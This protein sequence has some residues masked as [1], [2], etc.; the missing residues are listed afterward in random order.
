MKFQKSTLIRPAKAIVS[1][2]A[3][4]FLCSATDAGFT[5]PS[6]PVTLNNPEEINQI[7]VQNSNESNF[8]AN[9]I[10]L[11]GG[12]IYRF[13]SSTGSN[14]VAVLFGYSM[15]GNYSNSNKVAIVA[16]V[17][18]NYNTLSNDCLLYSSSNMSF[19]ANSLG[20]DQTAAN[21]SRQN[22]VSALAKAYIAHY[23]ENPDK[24]EIRGV[25][26]Q[27]STLDKIIKNNG[28]TAVNNLRLSFGKNNEGNIVVIVSAM[29]AGTRGVEVDMLDGSSL[30]PN[31]C[32]FY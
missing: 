19:Q 5:R 2:A 4:T 30:C 8:F 32:D 17:D 10:G 26:L 1:I 6:N 9:S 7:L 29:S 27:R 28:T 13:M 23:E 3:F 31:N 22:I 16:P 15:A 24:A 14:T 20:D 12:D 11:N 25:L 18:R 21:S